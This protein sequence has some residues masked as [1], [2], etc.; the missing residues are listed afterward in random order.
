MHCSKKGRLHGTVTSTKKSTALILVYIHMTSDGTPDSSRGRP[1][2]LTLS[3]GLRDELADEI[4]HLL[5]VPCVDTCGGKKHH[6][7]SYQFTLSGASLE[8]GDTC[9]GNDRFTGH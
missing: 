1:K 6:L 7:S 3:L 8:P 2:V 4:K 9:P 5:G